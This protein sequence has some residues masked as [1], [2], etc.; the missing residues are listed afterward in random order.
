M[1]Q[2]YEERRSTAQKTYDEEVKARVQA[3]INFLYKEYGAGWVDKIDMRT[4]ELSDGAS[5]ILG[6]VF[7]EKTEE[8]D[9]F[10][11]DGYVWASDNFF[12]GESGSEFGF[13]T[14]N[15]AESWGPLQEAWEE[16]LKLL[17]REPL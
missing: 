9:G 5:C 3:G 7:D 8:E 13:C 1:T 14:I 2:T 16:E 11:D 15:G 6:Q 12:G 4:L 10:F 17:K